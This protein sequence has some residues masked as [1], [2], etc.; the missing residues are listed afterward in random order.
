MEGANMDKLGIPRIPIESTKD[1]SLCYPK[2]PT[3]ITHPQQQWK[4][5][6]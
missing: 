2:L 1:S 5:P 6:Q 3:L 4:D